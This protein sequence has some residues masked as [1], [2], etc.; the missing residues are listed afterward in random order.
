VEKFKSEVVDKFYNYLNENGQIVFAYIFDYHN[1]N[2]SDKRNMLNNQNYRKSIYK[3][4]YSEIP[5][6]SA[7]VGISEDA[8]CLLEKK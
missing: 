4:N 8:V 1:E 5:I 6:K 2:N 7:M 3:D